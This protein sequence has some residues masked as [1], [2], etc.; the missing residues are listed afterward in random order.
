MT[1]RINISN[2]YRDKFYRL[3]KVFFTGNR[4]KNMSNNAK[5]AW[6]ILRDRV[7]LSARNNWVDENGDIY[8]IYTNENLMEIL[9]V[10]SK[11]TLSKIKKELI[12]AELLEQERTGLNKPNKLYLLNPRVTED[13]I[14]K[15]KEKESKELQGNHFENLEYTGSPKIGLPFSESRSTINGL[16]EVQKMDSN[17]TELNDTEFRYKD[18]KDQSKTLINNSFNN[19][20][21]KPNVNMD[22]LLIENYII[23]NSL[24]EKYN[25]N[26]LNLLVTN[27]QGNI[28]YFKENIDVIESA[29]RTVDSNKGTSLGIE[30]YE[31]SEF[32]QE[33]KNDLNRTVH[34]VLFKIRTDK[35]GEIKDPKSYLF[36]SIKTTA[37]R[38]AN[39]YN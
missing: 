28:K 25:K 19:L 13:D 10:K 33:F 32:S 7:D 37:I 5:I 20:L 6:S 24:E 31:T 38:W 39:N 8:F 11:S 14:Y 35:K 34:Q 21:R 18:N 3:P 15:I 22:E 36:T 30:L 2:E 16:Q 27:A 26:L 29:I 12:T 9:N 1:N 23:E 4:Y 17:D